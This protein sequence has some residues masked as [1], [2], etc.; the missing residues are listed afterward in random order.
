MEKW[1][2]SLPKDTKLRMLSET[3]SFGAFF[4]LSKILLDAPIQDGGISTDEI[5]VV[6]RKL[7]Y[8]QPRIQVKLKGDM[9]Q[10]F[11]ESQEEDELFDDQDPMGL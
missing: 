7:G 6:A 3:E 2:L 9:A 4:Q 5:R 8:E 1:F 11:N 10:Q